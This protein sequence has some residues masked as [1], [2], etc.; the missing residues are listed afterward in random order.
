VSRQAVANNSSNGA[1]AGTSLPTKDYTCP[2]GTVVKVMA[3]DYGF[4]SGSGRLYEE[5]YGE[6]PGGI[7][8]LVGIL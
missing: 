4:R 6:V 8:Q 1:K 7:F 5:Q 2:D 3:C